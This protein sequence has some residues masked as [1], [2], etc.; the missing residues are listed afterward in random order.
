[1]QK[2]QQSKKKGDNMK[3]TDRNP[4]SGHGQH[5]RGENK[6]LVK[7]MHARI[8]VLKREESMLS[9]SSLNIIFN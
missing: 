9:F 8:Q 7:G 1:M 6:Q 2:Y 3:Y 5:G 4:A